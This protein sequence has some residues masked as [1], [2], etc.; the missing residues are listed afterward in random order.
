M[1]ELF[2]DFEFN[3]KPEQ[4]ITSVSGMPLPEDLPVIYERA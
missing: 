4:M 2:K 1:E 3:D